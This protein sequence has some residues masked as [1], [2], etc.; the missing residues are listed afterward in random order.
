MSNKNLIKAVMLNEILDAKKISYSKENYNFNASEV[1]VD[2][3][4]RY[5]INK[6]GAIGLY[7]A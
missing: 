2:K 5:H 4:Y 7:E 3:D 1:F 6:H